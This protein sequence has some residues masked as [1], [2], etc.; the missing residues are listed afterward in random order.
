MARK[1]I[2]IDVTAVEPL[3]VTGL[4]FAVVSGWGWCSCQEESRTLT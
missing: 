2:V 3:T 4:A 1:F